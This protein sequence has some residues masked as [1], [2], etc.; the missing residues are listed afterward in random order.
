[1]CATQKESEDVMISLLMGCWYSGV[2]LWMSQD[3]PCTVRSSC[4]LY[5][6]KYTG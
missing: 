4:N 6:R 3:L 5:L 2:S 1:M